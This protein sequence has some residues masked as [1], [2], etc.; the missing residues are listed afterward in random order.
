M[1]TTASMTSTR[2]HSCDLCDT[3][4]APLTSAEV[5]QVETRLGRE[6]PPFLKGLLTEVGDGGYGFAYGDGE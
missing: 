4:G 5:A 2:R 6:L 3:A 1:T